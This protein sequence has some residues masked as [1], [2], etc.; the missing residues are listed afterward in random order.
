MTCIVLDD[1][2]PTEQVQN[3]PDSDE[4]DN[5]GR[6]YQNPSYG[7][8]YSDQ[9]QY[10]DQNY[11][12]M[13]SEGEEEDHQYHEDFN[14]EEEEEV[15]PKE[16]SPKHNVEFEINFDNTIDRRKKNA[17]MEQFLKKKEE[18][19]RIRKLEV[20]KKKEKIKAK[21]ETDQKYSRKVP[22]SA[23]INPSQ[24]QNT[25]SNDIKHEP[26]DLNT[27]KQ[28]KKKAN[29]LTSPITELKNK[30]KRNNLIDAQSE[31][32]KSISSGPAK[33]PFTVG[34]RRPTVPIKIAEKSNKK[35]IM[36]AIRSV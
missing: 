3:Y 32:S 26:A 22:Q 19:E 29:K 7:Q 21:P 12:N 1:F 20:Q 36:N 18:K 30:V 34:Y 9:D 24:K 2:S 17:K 28:G 8:N 25:V 10:Q 16:E 31:E 4:H 11:E 13:E 6:Q 23:K 27:V 5:Y 35:L 15:T 14:E 33:S